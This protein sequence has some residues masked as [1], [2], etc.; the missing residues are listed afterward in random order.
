MNRNKTYSGLDAD[1]YGGMTPTGTV[2]RD[3]Q[4]FGLIPE[5]E[6]CA[7]W[8][9]DR[10]E[11]LYD[12]VSKAWHPYGHLV[13]QLPEELRVRHRRIYEAAVATAR[14][15]GWSPDQYPD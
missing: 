6:T 7:G 1:H 12:E 4:V 8:S 5:E 15:R 13:G 14:A 2:I 10:I 3:A 11:A 9:R